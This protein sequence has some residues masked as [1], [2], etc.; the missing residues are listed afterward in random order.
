MKRLVAVIALVVAAT[1]G[2]ADAKPWGAPSLP[3]FN[4]IDALSCPVLAIMFP[5]E[6]D[7]PGL[8]DCP[9]YND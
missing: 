5:P 1:P 3:I 4:L 2:V 7:V 6:G 9:P 8:W